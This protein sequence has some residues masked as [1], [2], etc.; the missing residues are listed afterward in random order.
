MP[1]IT[2]ISQSQ[3]STLTKL[4]AAALKEAVKA[5]HIPKPTK[6]GY[7]QAE[8][9]RGAFVFYAETAKGRQSKWPNFFTSQ[10]QAAAVTGIPSHVWAAWKRAGCPAFADARIRPHEAVVWAIM[11]EQKAGEQLD[12]NAERAGLA[13]EQKDKLALENETTRRTL[14]PS[15]E[16]A[17]HMRETWQPVREAIIPMADVLAPLVNPADP[18]HARQHLIEW[19]DEFFQRCTLKLPHN[20]S[21][22]S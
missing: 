6:D 7:P 22:A 8:A 20:D 3:L 11:H 17:D 12:L 16:V 9:I 14:L 19:R 21:P 15:E 18:E 10:T 4:D 5:G 1:D 13:K 2:F